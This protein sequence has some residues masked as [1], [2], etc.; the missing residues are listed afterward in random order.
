MLE[1]LYLSL[2]E[3]LEEL[4]K[5]GIAKGRLVF[6]H[7]D[8]SSLVSL[9]CT[10]TP[11]PDGDARCKPV[12]ELHWLWCQRID[13]SA[14]GPLDVSILDRGVLL[15]SALYGWVVDHN[16][17]RVVVPALVQEAAPFI[18]QAHKDQWGF[19]SSM[20]GAFPGAGRT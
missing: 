13:S 19:F 16:G 20:S 12:K 15:V 3:Y 8:D 7:M 6:V 18:L 2:A 11:F 9:N 1:V 10:R 14:C 5:V 17:G 4:H